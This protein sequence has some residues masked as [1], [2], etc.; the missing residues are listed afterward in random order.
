MIRRPRT[1]RQLCVLSL[2]LLTAACA[3][4]PQN[5][6]PR[7]PEAIPSAPPRGEPRNYLG[8]TAAALRQAMGAPAFAR[9]DGVT[10]MWRYDG[11]ACRAFFFLYDAQ[12][13]KVVRHVET[14]PRG[15]NSAADPGCLA[16][17]RASPAKT[18]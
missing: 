16:A 1:I 7:S 14:L 12:N 17:L 5:Q 2:L 15:I 8:M 4:K 10:E 13:S 11:A 3:S 9:Q 6:V 18:S